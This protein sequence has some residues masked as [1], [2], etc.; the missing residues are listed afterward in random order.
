MSPHTLRHTFAT[1]LLAGGCDLRSVQ[2]MLGHADVATTQI[3]THVSAENLKDVYFRAHPRAV[4]RSRPPL[5]V[6]GCRR[7]RSLLR[8]RG[9]PSRPAAGAIA[10]SPPDPSRP[11][12]A[13]RDAE[14]SYPAAGIRFQAPDDWTFEPGQA[15]LVTSTADGT[16]TIAV[17]R[18]LRTE[19][20]PREDA[21]L[22]DAQR[23]LVDAA[24]VR[25]PRSS[26]T[27][28]AG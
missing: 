5:E 14:R 21:D 10:S 7:L 11:A 28:P 3:Y 19:P 26:S 8:A 27:A 9:A 20:L 16:A 18:Y 17:W 4:A 12:S 24:K 25:D 1:H 13:L 22:A 23:R 6:V 2:E 15:P